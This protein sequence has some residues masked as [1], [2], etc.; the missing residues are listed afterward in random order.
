[1]P[2]LTLAA[3]FA[4]R[5]FGGSQGRVAATL[6]FAASGCA[7][8]MLAKHLVRPQG[9]I[10][11]V[12]PLVALLWVVIVQWQRRSLRSALAAGVFAGALL[13]MLQATAAVTPT[14]FVDRALSRPGRALRDVR[15][16][17]DRDMVRA[18]GDERFA[19]QR[20]AAVPE[21]AQ[22]ADQ[23]GRSLRGSGD[24]RFAVLGDAQLLYVLFG[25]D[26][27]FHI[28]LYDAA[29]ISEQRRWI[30]GVRRQ[31]PRRL[32]WRHDF[33]VDFVPYPVRTPL[34]FAHAIARYV[35]QTLG[36]SADVLRRRRPG[37]PVALRYWGRRLG[38]VVDLG[39]IP[40]YSRGDEPARCDGG[41]GCAAYAIVTAPG[42]V[43]ARRVSLRLTGTPYGIVFSTR[44]GVS[45]YAVRLDRLWFWPYAGGRSARLSSAT[46][47]WRVER[48]GVKAGSDLY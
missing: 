45:R 18:A 1:M 32:V 14:R 38:F 29:R 25:Q 4:L 44:K 15:L 47:T 37:E 7:T 42:G 13:G 35:P 11:I 16:A 3:A 41:A 34:V 2:A 48:V 12:I 46:P 33:A 24:D 30:D 40:S 20:F 8:V 23:L 22:I 31:R 9:P 36:H 6:L 19:V 27:P 10:V 17:A 28:S 39:G 21:K 26:P 43:T 5:R